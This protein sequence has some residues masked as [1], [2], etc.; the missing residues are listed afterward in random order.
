MKEADGSAKERQASGL[1][2]RARTHHPQRDRSQSS[3][4]E[5]NKFVPK[6]ENWV[7]SEPQIA[8]VETLAPVALQRY[9]LA[10]LKAI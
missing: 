9:P 8:T 2:N 10:T 3:S 4:G 5:A 1:R 7:F 6:L